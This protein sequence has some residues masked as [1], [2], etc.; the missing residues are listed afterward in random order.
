M[1]NGLPYVVQPSHTCMVHVQTPRL[2]LFLKL[3]WTHFSN[4][5][6]ELLYIAKK[7]SNSEKLYHQ[8]QWLECYTKAR[9]SFSGGPHA[10]VNMAD[11][12]G[13]AGSWT[14]SGSKEVMEVPK[15]F[16]DLQKLGVR[17]VVQCTKQTCHF[18]H[19]STHIHFHT[20]RGIGPQAKPETHLLS[21][22]PGFRVIGK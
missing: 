8:M 10:P 14:V 19:F 9:L 18:L 6:I 13:S 22:L 15:N 11:S 5:Q 21:T 2:N 17:N 3:C 12:M 16:K 7:L 20:T 4:K 1:A